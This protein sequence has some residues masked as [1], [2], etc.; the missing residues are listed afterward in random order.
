MILE[1]ISS[2]S[3]LQIE[4]LIG[5]NDIYIPNLHIYGTVKNYFGFMLKVK[6]EYI[7]FILINNECMKLDRKD[8]NYNIQQLFIKDEFKKSDFGKKTVFNVLDNISGNWEIKP[9]NNE[10]TIFWEKIIGEYTNNNYT[11]ITIDR[12]TIITLKS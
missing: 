4:K 5:T 8:N 1:Q 6:S 3:I 11:K 10:V 7:G 2:K 12:R 9:N